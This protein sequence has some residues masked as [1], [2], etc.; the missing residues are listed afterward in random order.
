MACHQRLESAKDNAESIAKLNE[1]RKA[2]FRKVC[3]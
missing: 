1:E 3:A 2:A